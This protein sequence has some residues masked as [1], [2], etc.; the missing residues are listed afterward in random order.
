M[1]WSCN[2]WVTLLVPA[3]HL[4]LD[5]YSLVLVVHLVFNPAQCVFIQTTV[6]QL[7][8]EVLMGDSVESFTEVKVDNVLICF[9][10]ICQDTRFITEV[11]PTD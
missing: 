10:L 11:Y 3:F 8:C 9:P 1:E 6:H 5:H 7:L 4:D 2:L